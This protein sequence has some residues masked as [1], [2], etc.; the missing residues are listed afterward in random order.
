MVAG[1]AVAETITKTIT[2]ITNLK[3]LTITN[4]DRTSKAT[5]TA[6]FKSRKAYPKRPPIEVLFLG[7]VA[8]AVVVT[9]RSMHVPRFQKL[10]LEALASNASRRR[11]RL[12]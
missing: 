3:L 8:L 4:R 5:R 12:R 1:A 9:K 11:K 2:M 7:S 10:R 6:A